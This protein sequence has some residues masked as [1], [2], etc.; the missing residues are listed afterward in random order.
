MKLNRN[1]NVNW[2]IIV[3]I[4]VALSNFLYGQYN[5]EEKELTICEER[6]IDVFNTFDDDFIIYTKDSL[7]LDN[8]RIIEYSI[9][10]TGNT[11][12]VGTGVQ[13][14]LLVD[15]NS[16]RIANDSVIVKISGKDESVKL[17]DNHIRFK[18]IRPNEKITLICASN[19]NI[20]NHLVYISD[21]DIKDV[22]IVY[23]KRNSRL[24]TFEKTT[25]TN[26]WLCVGGFLLNLMVVLAIVAMSLLEVAK[27]LKTWKKVLLFLSFLCL[28][29]TLMLPIRWLL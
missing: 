26:R 18:Q 3:P 17:F 14:D 20:E 29:Y 21:R 15:G 27:E 12:I 9:T 25:S 11:T 24:T 22:N 28:I 5:L 6:Q 8:H 13:S 23:T 19:Q 2:S 1:V 16:L 7:R 10:N 4:L